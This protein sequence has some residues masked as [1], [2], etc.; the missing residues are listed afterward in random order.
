M[1]SN[2]VDIVLQLIHIDK[3]MTEL[4]TQAYDLQKLFKICLRDYKTN[5]MNEVEIKSL[6]IGERLATTTNIIPSEINEKGKN[7]I[8]TEC[9][10]SVEMNMNCHSSDEVS[11][12]SQNKEFKVEY[13][14]DSVVGKCIYIYIY[15]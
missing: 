6:K 7:P 2:A 14:D 9:L 13:V 15:I 3:G 5:L 12:E 10:K 4:L 8:L 1:S 11:K